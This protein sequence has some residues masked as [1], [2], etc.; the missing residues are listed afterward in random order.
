MNILQKRAWKNLGIM[1][2]LLLLT[3]IYL[4]ISVHV[5][6]EGDV[7]GS[8]LSLF[9]GL[10]AGVIFLLR[11][12]PKV[13]LLDEREKLIAHTASTYS[14]LVFI[15]FMVF[16]SQC[17]FIFSSARDKIPVYLP[18]LLSVSGLFIAQLVSSAIVLI[19]CAKEQQDG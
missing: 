5:N 8:I 9:V 16:T 6:A 2:S 11:N 1:F 13:N 3:V 19:W 10:T 14:S 7:F 17:I 12:L 18:F 15:F 4:S